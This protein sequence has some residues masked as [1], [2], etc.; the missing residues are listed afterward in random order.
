M[1][2]PSSAGRALLSFPRSRFAAIVL[3]ALAWLGTAYELDNIGIEVFDR[4]LKAFPFE[5]WILAFVLTILTCWWMPN[6]LP[7]RGLSAIFMLF[8]AEMFHVIRLE[9]TNWRLVLVVIAY[10][11][12]AMGMFG[13][14]YPW[15]VRQFFAWMAEK[16]YR[17][18]ALGSVLSATGLLCLALGCVL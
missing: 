14:F 3:C 5:L 18:R 9:P 1:I 10:A 17:I 7:I 13:M 11:C 8:P 4:F 15:R 16:T 12:I 2:C 6:L